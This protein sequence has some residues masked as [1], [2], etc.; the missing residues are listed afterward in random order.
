MT[1]KEMLEIFAALNFSQKQLL[2]E[3]VFSE[4]ATGCEARLLMECFQRWP[5]LTVEGYEEPV[6]EEPR[7]FYDP[8]IADIPY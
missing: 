6:Q 2:R 7:Q 3:V 4:N 8:V 5:Q 1:K